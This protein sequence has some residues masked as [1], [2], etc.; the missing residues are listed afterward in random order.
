MIQRII[1]KIFAVANRLKEL[2]IKKERINYWTKTTKTRLAQLPQV[3]E[4]LT[5]SEKREIDSFFSP[6]IKVNHLFHEFYK[7]ATG[8]FD[9]RNI[10][11]D[12]YYSRID[13]YYNDW[14]Y[15]STMDNKTFYPWLFRNIKQP[16][17]ICYRQNG[18]WFDKNGKI[19]SITTAIELI[20]SA[21]IAFIKNATLSMGGKGIF[22]YDKNNYTDEIKDFIQSTPNDIIVQEGITQ[23]KH[24]SLLNE[25]SVNTIRIVT[26]LRK[27]GTVRICST[28]VRMGLKGSKVDNASSGGLS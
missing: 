4:S 10:P 3:Y 28:C 9:V 25:S 14:A 19:L 26:F 12:I 5:N 6:Y 13:P 23:S 1:F 21:K 24:L 7:K 22:V 17:N 15:A 11:D 8:K 2:Y 16:E 27:D 20:K 18:Y